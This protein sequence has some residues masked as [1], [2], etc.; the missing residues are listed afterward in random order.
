MKAWVA[1][2]L[3]A[4]AVLLLSTALESLGALGVLA[5]ASGFVLMVLSSFKESENVEK[6][7]D[8]Q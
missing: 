5:L 6:P 3:L 4:L 8:R 7:S 1:I 2:V